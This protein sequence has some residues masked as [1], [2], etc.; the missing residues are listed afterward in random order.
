VVAFTRLSLFRQFLLALFCILLVG[1]VVIG[2]VVNQEIEQGVVQRTTALTALYVDSLVGHHLPP[3]AATAELDPDEWA[4]MDSLFTDSAF[5]RQVVTF[6]LWGADGRIL[7]STNRALMNQPLPLPREVARGFAGAVQSEILPADPRDGYARPGFRLLN[8]Y[9]P[10]RPEDS[11]RIVAVAEI[12]QRTDEL[13]REVGAAQQQSW[14]VM[15]GATLLLY[16]LLAGLVGR[17]SNLIDRQQ[18]ERQEQLRQLAA[19]LEQNEQLNERIRGAAARSS[20][21]NERFLRRLASELHDGPCQDLGLALLRIESLAENCAPP[22]PGPDS[23]SAPGLVPSTDFPTVQQALRSALAELRTISTGLWLPALESLSPAEV[24][25]R[26]IYDYQDKTG[27]QVP[28]ALA[29]LPPT[30]P[31]PVKITLY[32]LLQEALINGFRHAE[33]AG[34]EV[35]LWVEDDH[36][37]AQVVDAGAGFDPRTMG[38][39]GHLGL[40]GMRERVELLGGAFAVQST[41][42]QGTR[43]QARLPLTL[44]EDEHGGAD[45]GHRGG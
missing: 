32:R 10:V 29:P 39:N 4:M 38:Q 21:L 8:T 9:A 22:A 33:G 14:A 6:S 24:T 15:V 19:L 2:L 34:Q 1:M 25:Q 44:P 43:I 5:G 23:L 45:S 31:L 41:P 27:V 13:D 17:A 42:G 37:C 26:A 36:L 40:V 20:A 11:D 28:V 18:R 30:A 16:L 7:Y 35:R 12:S 3:M